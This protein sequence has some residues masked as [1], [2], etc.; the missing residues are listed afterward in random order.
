MD[1]E[2][3]E[4]TEYSLPPEQELRYGRRNEFPWKTATICLTI[5]VVAVAFG[6]IGLLMVLTENPTQNPLS[7]FTSPYPSDEWPTTTKFGYNRPSSQLTPSLVLWGG[8]RRSV[9]QYKY[10]PYQYAGLTS[11]SVPQY[12]SEMILKALFS[13]RSMNQAKKWQTEG[14]FLWCGDAASPD[15]TIVSLEPATSGTASVPYACPASPQAQALFN[16]GLTQRYG[17]NDNEAAC[18]FL[19]A[20]EVDSTCAL[21]YLGYTLAVGPNV[22]IGFVASEAVYSSIVDSLQKAKAVVDSGKLSGITLAVTSGLLHALIT[23]YMP[24]ATVNPGQSLAQRLAEVAQD[25]IRHFQAYS[26]NIAENTAAYSDAMEALQARFPDDTMISLLTVSALMQN[27]AWK[28]WK[29]GQEYPSM[30]GVPSIGNV[31]SGILPSNAKANQLLNGVLSREP[32]S[33]G[34]NHYYIHNVEGGPQPRWALAA[35]ETL[36]TLDPSGHVQHMPG[37]TFNRIG[38]WAQ[39]IEWNKRANYADFQWA[40]RRAGG[41]FLSPLYGYQAHD[42]AFQIEAA[43]HSYSWAEAAAAIALQSDLSHYLISAAPTVAGYAAPIRNEYLVPLRFGLYHNVLEALDASPVDAEGQYQTPS[44]AVKLHSVLAARLFAESVAAARTQQP[45]RAK[46]ALTALLK[47]E[48]GNANDEPQ[49]RAIEAACDRLLAKWEGLKARAL[50]LDQVESTTSTATVDNGL[51][52]RCIGLLI[53]LGDRLLAQEA[54]NEAETVY[55]RALRVQQQLQ[56]D[57]PSPFFFPVVAT[58]GKLHM[59]RG[60]FRKAAAAFRE[61]LFTWPQS[62]QLV[63][64]LDAAL[65]AQGQGAEVQVATLVEQVCQYNDTDFVLACL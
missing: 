4:R 24:A 52:Q 39:S 61:G 36:Q 17:F 42:I 8:P 41:L 47:L 34:A 21:A 14:R 6:L 33:V 29:P 11:I 60:E 18:S 9:G 25:P 1:I 65:R 40:I 30:P 19:K 31:S 28:W 2:A 7:A 10:E 26:Q 5:V 63:M 37:H 16:Q 55:R 15:S 22:N 3:P 62:F 51:A 12:F 64:G 38:R 46:E 27:P 56:Y 49:D 23:R 59:Q 53:P 57:E 20:V 54:Y 32:F 35:A 48:G 58:L 44:G 43:L 13:A 45:L 50:E